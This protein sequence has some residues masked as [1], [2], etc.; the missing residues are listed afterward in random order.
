[1]NSIKLREQHQ[2]KLTGNFLLFF[3]L[4]ACCFALELYM[5]SE[6]KCSCQWLFLVRHRGGFP[7]E[8][9]NFFGF[10]FSRLVQIF[11]RSN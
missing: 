9:I 7:L 3:F 6:G 8:I 5:S 4:H 10:S 1:M 11:I 2:K